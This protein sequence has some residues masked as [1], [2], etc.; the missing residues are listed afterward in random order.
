MSNTITRR[1]FGATAPPLPSPRRSS[2]GPMPPHRS[3][4]GALWTPRHRIRATSRSAISSARS[5]RRRTARSPP[6]CSRAARCS[7]TCKWSRRWC[8]ARWRWPALAPGPSPASWP[9]RTFSQLP[10]LYGRPIDVVHKATDGKGGKFVN[11]GDHR[12]AACRGAGGWFDLG[13]N[14]WFSTRKPLNSLADLAGHEA[15][16]PGRRAELFPHPLFRRHSQCHRLA[17]RAAGAC[18]RARSMG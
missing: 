15:A 6:S 8:R 4:C 11:T 5:R 3:S 18:R 16:Q 2:A 14:N 1:A 13:F 17:G 12:Q 9:T 10:A 7:P